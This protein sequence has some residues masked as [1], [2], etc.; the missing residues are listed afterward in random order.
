M[1]A[2]TVDMRRRGGQHDD[3]DDDDDDD[4]NVGLMRVDDVYCY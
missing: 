4:G 2:A 3:D 1:C